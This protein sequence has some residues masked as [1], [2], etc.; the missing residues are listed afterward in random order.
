MREAQDFRLLVRK[1][2]YPYEY[3]YSFEKMDEQQL[4]PK[5]AFCLMLTDS[6]I[7]DEDKEHAYK[8][9]DTVKLGRMRACHNLY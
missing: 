6:N 8:V 1:G 4:P 3:M 2:V 7:S 9:W 5:E